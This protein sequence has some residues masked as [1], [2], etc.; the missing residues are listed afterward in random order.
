MQGIY[1]AALITTILVLAVYGS[2]VYK[3]KV[4]ADKRWLWLAFLM[5][6]PMQPL[7]FYL[8]RLPINDWLLATMGKES[9]LYQAM[10]LFYAPLTEEPA[11]LVPL[12]I[13]FIWRDINKETFVRYAIAIGLGFGIG[14][15][16]FV[17]ERITHVPEF[18]A[19]PFYYFGGFLGERFQ[20]CL[21]HGVFTSLVLW[22]L[23]NN[24]F[25]GFWLAVMAHFFGNFPIFLMAKGVGGIGQTAWQTIISLWLMFYFLGGIALL[26]YF[27][28]GRA[29]IGRFIFG[30]TKCPECS[31]IYDSPVFGLNLGTRRYERCPQCRKW[32]L[33][34]IADKVTDD[35]DI[36]ING[37]PST[38]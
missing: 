17:A 15:I 22:R 6:L 13:P 3:M 29:S 12:L 24:V 2:F 19:M 37:Q 1:I 28:Y 32:H 34:G 31:Q 33:I 25:F 30:K 9:G 27:T 8:V 20:V 4:P 23:R 10:T 5:V 18:A 36:P 7:A 38:V 11:K 21:L 35:E 14:E 26:A 16:W